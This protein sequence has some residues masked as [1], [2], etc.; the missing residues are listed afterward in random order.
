MMQYGANGPLFK[1]VRHIYDQMLSQVKAGGKTSHTY[2]TEMGVLQGDPLSG[3]LWIIFIAV[4]GETLFGTGKSPSVA[5][6]VVKLLL[7]ADDIALIAY[8][9]GELDIL[10]RGLQQYCDEN[11]LTISVKKSV[12]VAFY[13]SVDGKEIAEPVLLN[14][15]PL[16]EEEWTNY[17]GVTFDSNNPLQY[18]RHIRRRANAAKLKADALLRTMEL[19]N[20]KIPVVELLALYKTEVLSRMLFGAELTITCAKIDEFHKVEMGFLRRLLRISDTSTVEGVYLELDMLPV[21]IKRLEKALT[22]FLYASSS[23]GPAL[24]R[25]A[26][27]SNYQLPPHAWAARRSWFFALRLELRKYGVGIP[28]M[29]GP[30]GID[31]STLGYDQAEVTTTLITQLRTAARQQMIDSLALKTK[32]SILNASPPTAFMRYL[33]ILSPRQREQ[34]TR[35]R[36][37]EHY[38]AVER[39]RYTRPVTLHDERKCRLCPHGEVEDEIHVLADCNGNSTIVDARILLGDELMKLDP[40]VVGVNFRS[41]GTNFRS[42]EVWSTLWNSQEE[43]VI[44]VVGRFVSTCFEQVKALGPYQ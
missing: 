9:R 10:L 27:W 35:L 36:L 28:G 26:M 2:R 42:L 38:L 29:S 31:W 37:S 11:L 4:L 32:F 34:M 6:I 39:G 16:T 18:Q 22:F 21:R 44:K 20:H 13:N 5:G 17:I 8:T 24:V 33:D 19:S 23:E 25:H 3:L 1:L 40:K 14:G 30:E 7:M 43:E 15:V 12:I 41:Q